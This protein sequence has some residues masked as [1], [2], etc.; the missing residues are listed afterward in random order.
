ML[1]PAPLMLDRLSSTGMTRG[2]RSSEKEVPYSGHN[3]LAESSQRMD[4]I[5]SGFAAIVISSGDE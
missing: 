3:S 4:T 1:P 2:I 5:W